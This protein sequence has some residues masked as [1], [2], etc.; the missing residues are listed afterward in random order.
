MVCCIHM[1]H[2]KF[3]TLSKLLYMKQMANKGL[4]ARDIY[5]GI[6]FSD[7]YFGEKRGEGC[8]FSVIKT[9]HGQSC[10][11]RDVFSSASVR[12]ER[13]GLGGVFVGMFVL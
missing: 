6:C 7:L 5:G 8:N 2:I 9:D 13:G 1:T 11:F 10:V 4:H 12:G 3:A